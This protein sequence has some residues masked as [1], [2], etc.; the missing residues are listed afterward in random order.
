M[1]EAYL[2]MR[3]KD[4]QDAKE[5]LLHKAADT[6]QVSGVRVEKGNILVVYVES[7]K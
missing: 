6:A 3:A 1:V 4:N 2:A 5:I 7:V